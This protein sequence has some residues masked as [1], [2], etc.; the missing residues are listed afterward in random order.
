MTRRCWFCEGVHRG[1]GITRG[2]CPEY[3]AFRRKVSLYAREGP[4]TRTALV[5]RAQGG[6]VAAQLFLYR[7]Y[8]CKVYAICRGCPEVHPHG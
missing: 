4:R 6:E 5:R 8:Q 3:K 7:H 1:V 2:A